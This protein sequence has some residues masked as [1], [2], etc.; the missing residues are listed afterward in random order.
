MAND[1]NSTGIIL[2]TIHRE[3]CEMRA[4]WRSQQ[5]VIL[6]TV[7]RTGPWKS[8]GEI[9]IS[10]EVIVREAFLI[11]V[12]ESV[13]PWGPLL[14]TCNWRRAKR[15]HPLMAHWWRGA[16][17]LHPYLMTRGLGRRANKLN[18]LL[19]NAMT[20][21]WRGAAT[22]HPCLIS[23][24][25]LRGR[26]LPR[27]PTRTAVSRRW[28]MGRE[29]LTTRLVTGPHGLTGRGGRGFLVLLSN[30]SFHGCLPI[31]LLSIPH[32]RRPVSTEV[33]SGQPSTS[34]ST[35]IHAGLTFLMIIVK[36]AKMG[37]PRESQMLLT[38][39]PAWFRHFHKRI[40]VLH[41]Q[42]KQPT[43][44]RK[45]GKRTFLSRK[46]GDLKAANVYE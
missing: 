7:F 16:N 33:T 12:K 3:W 43:C 32:T 40:R 31:L 34:R 2:G 15:L 17:P 27:V 8:L 42:S 20:A 29:N 1:T 18:P 36:S 23:G 21:P 30:T 5:L 28:V 24:M 11:I 14:T 39:L 19:V 10:N 38:Q 4:R 46:T 45:R 13:N 26:T 35:P 41:T 6:T 25:D 37:A 44:V 9:I 22:L